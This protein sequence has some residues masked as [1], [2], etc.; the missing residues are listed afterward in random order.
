MHVTLIAGNHIWCHEA[1]NRTRHIK[2][3][4]KIHA[5]LGKPET[6][7]RATSTAQGHIPSRLPRDGS[8]Q[9]HLRECT[10]ECLVRNSWRWMLISASGG[11]LR[12]TRSRKSKGS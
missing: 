8:L 11:E 5:A 12:A 4:T 6:Y 7:L 2:T 1:R 9:D 3:G 10:G